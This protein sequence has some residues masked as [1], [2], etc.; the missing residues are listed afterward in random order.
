MGESGF[1]ARESRLYLLNRQQ[2]LSD[3]LLRSQIPFAPLTDD[4][5]Q[6]IGAHVCLPRERLHDVV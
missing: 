2:D 4:V 1:D 3:D 5:F 6:R